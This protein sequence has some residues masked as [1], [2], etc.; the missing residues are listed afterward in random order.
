MGKNNQLIGCPPYINKD[1]LRAEMYGQKIYEVRWEI[2]TTHKTL[3]LK[4]E[5]LYISTIQFEITSKE[6]IT[7][8][9]WAGSGLHDLYSYNVI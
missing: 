5:L 6:G 1:I 3:N 4:K 8:Q 9:N 7:C 2:T